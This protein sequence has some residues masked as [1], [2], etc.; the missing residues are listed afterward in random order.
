MTR[1]CE[2]KHF[3]LEARLLRE[4]VPDCDRYPLS[5]PAGQNLRQLVFHPSITY[6]IG[7]NGS[8]KST[9]LEALAVLARL[10][11]LVEGGS[12]F[13]IATHS[14]LL[15]DYPN[16]MMLALPATGLDQIS[17][18]ETER[19]RVARDS[20]RNPRRALKTLLADASTIDR[21]AE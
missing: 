18:E 10:H 14:P 13:I 12:Q 16:A 5:L 15:M 6:P 17:Y 4:R 3:L 19:F 11:A 21:E 2:A 1:V 20:L 8:G 7:E 9:R